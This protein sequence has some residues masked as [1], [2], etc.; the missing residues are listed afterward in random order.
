MYKEIY[1]M[2]IKTKVNDVHR[3]INTED[4]YLEYSKLVTA[5]DVD[6]SELNNFILERAIDSTTFDEVKQRLQN[7][8]KN[9]D[10]DE[11]LNDDSENEVENK[12]D[13][14]EKNEEEYDKEDDKKEKQT[15]E[16]KQIKD[17]DEKQIEE[18]VLDESDKQVKRRRGRPRKDSN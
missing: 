12:E 18:I 6:E 15:E 7:E 10:I 3:T 2:K 8:I 17:L 9:D 5:D 16:N 14:E 4:E 13:K 1:D 11:T